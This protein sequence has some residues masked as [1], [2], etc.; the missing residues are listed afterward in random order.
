MRNYLIKISALSA[1]ILAGVYLLLWI[2]RASEPTSPLQY[3][4]FSHYTHPEEQPIW[5]TDY[6]PFAVIVSF[7][8]ANII[9]FLIELFFVEPS[10]A[11]AHDS[12]NIIRH[13]QKNI[14]PMDHL[15]DALYTC[16]RL[17]ADKIES[18][19]ASQGISTTV[20]PTWTNRS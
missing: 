13:I 11:P 20:H 17:D 3:L 16:P 2:L 9:L 7:I 19:L 18:E 6:F 15:Q 4:A 8:G 12:G 10:Y 14:P 1:L 5:T